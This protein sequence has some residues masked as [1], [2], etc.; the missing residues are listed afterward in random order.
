MKHTLND[1]QT[2]TTFA[3]GLLDYCNSINLDLNIDSIIEAYNEKSRG[4]HN[5]NHIDTI[6]MNIYSDYKNGIITEHLA[7]KLIIVSYYHDI[8][9]DGNS[10]SNEEYSA[11]RFLTDVKNSINMETLDIYNCIIAT[12]HHVSIGNV[13]EKFNKYDMNILLSDFEEL[14][15]YEKGIRYEYKMFSDEDYI[16]ARTKF[17]EDCILKYPQN[18]RNLIKLLDYININY[19]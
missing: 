7:Y 2:D 12:K 13:A 16:N 17:I 11:A 19:N 5:L 10:T 6:N 1:L 8:I 3:K 9:Y 18:K 14:I 15:N 4:Y